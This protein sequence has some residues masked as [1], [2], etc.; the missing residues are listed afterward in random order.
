MTIWR[1]VGAG[2]A[3]ALCAVLLLALHA[4][5]ATSRYQA[6]AIVE[7][8]SGISEPA[9]ERVLGVAWALRDA[10]PFPDA[11]TN[12]EPRAPAIVAQRADEE[13]GQLAVAAVVNVPRQLAFTALTDSSVTSAALANAAART[14]VRLRRRL[15]RQRARDAR[16]A[17]IVLEDAVGARG[18]RRALARIRK[19]QQA[20]QRNAVVL[21]QATATPA[22]PGASIAVSAV[23]LVLLVGL[24]SV[25][26]QHARN[27]GG[28]ASGADAGPR[29]STRH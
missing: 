17:A 28:R 11:V 27:D 26:W 24:A 10:G 29:R 21:V 7:F 8:R 18:T 5:T 25:W 1:V 23:A 4:V 6:R 16:G 3:I 20:E 14:Y 9:R 13:H 19:V 12:T 22:F 2:A 15:V